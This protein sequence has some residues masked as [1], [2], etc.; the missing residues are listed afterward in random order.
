M[1]EEVKELERRLALLLEKRDV[2]LARLDA[3]V[4]KSNQALWEAQAKLNDLNA[5]KARLG[6]E[7]RRIV[8]G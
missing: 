6:E 3:N 1:A 5:E 7:L 8:G 4:R 2:T